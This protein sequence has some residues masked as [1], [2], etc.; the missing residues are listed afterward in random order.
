M[1]GK[2]YCD[3]ARA[4]FES[5][6][7]NGTSA[8][9][10]ANL[11][12]GVAFD[13]EATCFRKYAAMFDNSTLQAPSSPIDSLISLITPDRKPTSRV[14]DA[15]ECKYKEQLV[16]FLQDNKKRA[17]LELPL[18]DTHLFDCAPGEEQRSYIFC[19]F[20][21]Y[22]FAYLNNITLHIHYCEDVKD[23]SSATINIIELNKGCDEIHRIFY[24]N[25]HM[26]CAFKKNIQPI[27]FDTPP[28][29]L[30]I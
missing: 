28:M 1:E 10:C 20:F 25:M 18:P 29:Y 8:E 7:A 22:A 17:L 14:S 11:R 4:I 6:M 19:L 2:K 9:I 24:L 5:N 23:S 15:D 13:P 26:V 16:S 3:R 30:R 12:F 21:Y 27:T